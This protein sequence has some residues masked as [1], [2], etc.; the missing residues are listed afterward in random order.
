MS[1][2]IQY[3]RKGEVIATEEVYEHPSE[4]HMR[5]QCSRL[6]ADFADVSRTEEPML[7]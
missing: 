7:L 3:I 2:L 4:D 6:G 5:E 1:Y